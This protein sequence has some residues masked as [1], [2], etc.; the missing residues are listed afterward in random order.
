[1]NIDAAAI[2]QRKRLGQLTL[3]SPAT[4]LNLP[5]VKISPIVLK[6]QLVIHGAAFRLPGFT[7]GSPSLHA[8]HT[9]DSTDNTLSD[10]SDDSGTPTSA[11]PAGT[12]DDRRCPNNISAGPSNRFNRLASRTTSRDHI[13]NNQS[14]LTRRDCET[15]AQRHLARLPA[16]SKRTS[17]LT[18]ARPRDQ[19]RSLQSQATRPVEF[20]ALKLLGDRAPER[21][22][23]LR[24]LKHE[25]TLQIDRAVQAAGKLKVASSNAPVALN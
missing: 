9:E 10:A 6:Q 17:L 15:A 16:R 14:L 12:I 20:P 8:S 4:F 23:A 7:T 18:R 5:A 13:F 25:R 21:F 19:S 22:G 1:M 11:L 24:K 2:N 3:N